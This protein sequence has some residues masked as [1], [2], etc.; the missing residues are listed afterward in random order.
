[1]SFLKRTYQ[2]FDPTAPSSQDRRGVCRYSVVQDNAW[3]GWWEG[4]AYQTTTA[5][6]IDI[7]LRGASLTVETF[8]PSEQ[9]VWFCP[10]GDVS[11]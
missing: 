2:P 11:Q 9:P 6:I 3:L 4:Q 7:S 1:M 8:P 10:P 5:K